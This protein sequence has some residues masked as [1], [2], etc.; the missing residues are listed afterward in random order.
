MLYSYQGRG[1]A[2]K[3]IV[4]HLTAAMELLDR[5]YKGGRPCYNKHG[6]KK[7][8]LAS[9][10]LRKKVFQRDGFRCKFCGSLDALTADHIIPEARGGKTTLD[11]LQ[12]LCMTC[13]LRKGVRISAP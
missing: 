2:L 11:N 12:T 7:K 4:E 5:A 3:H 1:M 9:P 10:S 6:P 8:Q 13:N